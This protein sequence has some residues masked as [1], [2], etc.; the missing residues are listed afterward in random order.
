MFLYYIKDSE[1]IS[2]MMD[3][4]SVLFYTE[5]NRLSKECDQQWKTKMI[6][7]KNSESKM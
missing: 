6:K 3:I 5:I 1:S 2:N 4:W 7:R